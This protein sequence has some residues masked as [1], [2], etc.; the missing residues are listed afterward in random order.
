MWNLKKIQQTNEFFKKKQTYRYR[1]QISVYQ[2]GV[3]Q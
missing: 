1:E 3:G 2:C